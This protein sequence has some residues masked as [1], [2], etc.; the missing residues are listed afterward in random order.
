MEAKQESSCRQRSIA[1][2]TFS[3][4]STEIERVFFLKLLIKIW[5]RF[6]VWQ[7]FATQ[8]WIFSQ[9]CLTCTTFGALTRISESVFIEAAYPISRLAV[10]A[11]YKHADVQQTATQY[12]NFA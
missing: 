7:V 3:S 6:F 11:Y 8:F 9:S 4:D 12:N 1:R 5:P 2:L 10:G